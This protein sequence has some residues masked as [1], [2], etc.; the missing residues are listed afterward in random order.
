MSR[1]QL[2]YISWFD[3]HCEVPLL[4][5]EGSRMS[6]SYKE[7]LSERTATGSSCNSLLLTVSTW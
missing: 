2:S 7:E 3:R 4:M 1:K 5:T 6:Y